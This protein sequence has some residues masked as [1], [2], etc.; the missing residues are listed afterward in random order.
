[1]SWAEG[2]SNPFTIVDARRIQMS[3]SHLSRAE[4]LSSRKCIM[5]LEDTWLDAIPDVQIRRNT[6]ATQE[7][8][9]PGCMQWRL[10]QSLSKKS[11]IGRVPIRP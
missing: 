11:A 6:E 5:T 7:I 1:M 8:R 9:L 2:A 4:I 3:S 10:H